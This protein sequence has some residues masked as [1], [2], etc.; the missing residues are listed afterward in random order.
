MLTVPVIT[1]KTGQVGRETCARAR[2]R[3]GPSAWKA[4]GRLE[5]EKPL[6]GAAA[7]DQK[8]AASALA[9]LHRH[10][11]VAAHRSL[12]LGGGLTQAL[13][14]LAGVTPAHAEGDEEGG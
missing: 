3:G 10:L 8:M 7:S 5:S 9:G 13:A 2:A 1:R 14:G 6:A 11:A 12:D 4:A